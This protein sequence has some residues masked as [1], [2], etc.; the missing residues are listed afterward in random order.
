VETV[1]PHWDGEMTRLVLALVLLWPI[2]AAAAF[3]NFSVGDIQ[4]FCVGTKSG[5]SNA[6]V[7]KYNICVLYL[8]G[9]SDAASTFGGWG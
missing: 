6:N 1:N 9:I 2:G 3:K 4:D 7:P 5:E 8:A